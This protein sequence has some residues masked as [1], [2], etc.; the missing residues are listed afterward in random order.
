MGTRGVL[1][2]VCSHAKDAVFLWGS[3]CA[4][5]PDGRLVTSEQVLVCLTAD[6]QKGDLFICQME[7]ATGSLSCRL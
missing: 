1:Q 2:H 4:S 7:K 5:L 3:L 6:R